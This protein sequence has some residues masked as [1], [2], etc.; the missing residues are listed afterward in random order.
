MRLRFGFIPWKDKKEPYALVSKEKVK[1]GL[2]WKV[3]R[4]LLF[5][6]DVKRTEDV[7]TFSYRGDD[8]ACMI[9][10]GIEPDRYGSY[11]V[12]HTFQN[13]PFIF[14][15]ETGHIV[16]DGH[17]EEFVNNACEYYSSRP[18]RGYEKD[19]QGRYKLNE[20]GL[21]VR[22]KIT[23]FWAYKG[24]LGN[25]M[26]RKMLKEYIEIDSLTL[27]QKLQMY[28]VGVAIT[29]VMLYLSALMFPEQFRMV[30]GL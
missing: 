2:F 13:D 14:D 27:L 26:K 4:E 29:F 21:Y 1:V 9:P 8:M 18:D 17:E 7:L 16:N 12:Y 3:G 15:P 19:A 20:A 30:F 25:V 6:N 24:N 28:G 11:E 22:K 23:D 5:I 10:P